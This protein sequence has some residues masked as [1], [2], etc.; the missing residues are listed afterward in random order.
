MSEPNAGSA[1]TDL[2]TKAEIKNDKIILNG[3]KRWCSG[4]GHSE[5]YVVYCK[6]SGAAPLLEEL[7]DVFRQNHKLQ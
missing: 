7:S 2:T 6:M 5:G 3:T 1:L 4:G